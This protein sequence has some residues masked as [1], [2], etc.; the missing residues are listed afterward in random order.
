[1][2]NWWS[3]SSWFLWTFW[4]QTW[5]HVD[6]LGGFS[7]CVL[8]EQQQLS[9]FCCFDLFSFLVNADLQ[10]D[11]ESW[12]IPKHHRVRLSLCVCFND[13]LN[14][15]WHT[16]LFPD[17][18]WLRDKVGAHDWPPLRCSRRPGDPSLTPRLLSP[19]TQ[20]WHEDAWMSMGEVSS[21]LSLERLNHQM[22]SGDWWLTD[23]SGVMTL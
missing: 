7:S 3:C 19:W 17:R 11:E 13:E 10:I 6:S 9:W 16:H 18:P 15:Q 5:P 1:M 14:T 21:R 12:W 22:I 23:Q 20:R 2:K 8:A 4:T